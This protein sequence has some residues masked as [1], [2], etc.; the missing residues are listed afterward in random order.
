MEDGTAE[1]RVKEV[2][3]RGPDLKTSE[4]GG[5]L[6]EAVVDLARPPSA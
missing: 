1:E 5:V 6:R 4:E 3:V 2:V